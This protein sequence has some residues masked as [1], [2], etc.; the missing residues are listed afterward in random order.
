MGIVQRSLNPAPG[1][2][3]VILSQEIQVDE[4]QTDRLIGRTERPFIEP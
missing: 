1:L 4:K 3:T 2:T